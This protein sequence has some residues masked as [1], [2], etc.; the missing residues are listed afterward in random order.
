MPYN[1]VLQASDSVLLIADQAYAEHLAQDIENTSGFSALY[2][3]TLDTG[4]F[5]GAPNEGAY[6]A[7][8]EHL[9]KLVS[10]ASAFAV[11][12]KW[13][14]GVGDGGGSNVERDGAAEIAMHA[15]R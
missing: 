5:D 6:A 15:K 11:T 3:W 1:L 14:K 9:K 7:H 13:D 8:W 10:R 4:D 2:D 12:G